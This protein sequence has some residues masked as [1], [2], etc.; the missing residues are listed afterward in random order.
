VLNGSG[1]EGSRV[2]VEVETQIVKTWAGWLTLEVARLQ[3]GLESP[4]R[5]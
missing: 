3:S 1:V 2:P 5:G 4:R